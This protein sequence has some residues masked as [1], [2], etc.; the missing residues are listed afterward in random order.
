MSHVFPDTQWLH[1]IH[2]CPYSAVKLAIITLH[3]QDFQNKAG[4][5][6]F[7]VTVPDWL[8]FRH[9]N[10]W[11]GLGKITVWFIITAFLEHVSE[12]PVFDPP[13]HPIHLHSWTF[14]PFTLHSSLL[15]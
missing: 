4:R 3:I 6:R 9:Q 5:E 15:V 1:H 10:T 2:C 12:S 7:Q 14:L 11:S 8:R 13:T